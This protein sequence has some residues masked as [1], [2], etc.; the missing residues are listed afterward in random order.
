MSKGASRKRILITGSTGQVGWELRRTLA[1]QGELLTPQ[2]GELDLS[3]PETV[4]ATVLRLRPDII[5][6][7]AAYTAVDKAESEPALAQAVNATSAGEL[8]K[9]AA[10]SNALLLHYS[11]DYV[12]DGQKASAYEVDDAVAPMSV[13]GRTKRD[14]ELAIAAS[15]ARH[16]IV[17]TAW[18]YGGRGKN[19]LLSMLRLAREREE[20]RVVADQFGAPTW[21][22]LL[23]QAS[24]QLL[25]AIPD[26]GNPSVPLLHLSSAGSTSWQGFAEAIVERGAA[27][28]LCKAVPVRAIATADYPTAAVRPAQSALSLTVLEREFGIHMP[29]WESA[30][31]L[32]LE[33]L[34]A[35][36]SA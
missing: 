4:A 20:L 19:F 1:T 36:R 32:C 24:A 6:N 9:A 22:R 10:R 7:P 8:A 27:L 28:G 33:D 34:A 17:R 14:G 5:V 30:L 18:V 35:A 29:H 21:S 3:R 16:L 23:A 15:G 25:Q 2:R 12:F 11:T 13:Y 26:G 31:K